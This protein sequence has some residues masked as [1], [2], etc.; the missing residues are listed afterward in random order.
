MDPN[1][2]SIMQGA[3]GA[4]GETAKYVEEVFSTDVYDGASGSNPINNG[5]DLDG[6]GGMVWFK[7]RNYDSGLSPVHDTERGVGQ[8]L[9][10]SSDAAQVAYN[11]FSSI[12]NNGFT[13][14]GTGTAYNN[15]SYKYASFTFRKAP[16]F[17]DIV[18]YTG[19]GN[20]SQTIAHSLD[21]IPG[22]IMVKCT[23]TDTTTW[24]VYHR[25]LGATKAVYL[26]LTSAEVTNVGHWNDTAPTSTH[27]TVG[28]SNDVNSLDD[29]YVAYI[30][31]HDDERFGDDEDES[32][33]KCGI[34]TG[35]G[36][37]DGPTI[38]LGWEP[39]WLIT[40]NSTYVT[41]NENWAIMDTMRQ[42]DNSHADGHYVWVS[43]NGSQPESSNAAY[44]INNQ[45]FQVAGSGAGNISGQNYI[46]MAMR[47][48]PMKTP[49]AGTEVFAVEYIPQPTSGTTK[50]TTNFPVD[51]SWANVPAQGT[52]GWTQDRVR[53][54]PKYGLHATSGNYPIVRTHDSYGESTFQPNNPY[55]LAADNTSLT[56]GNGINNGANL[57]FAFGR[58]PGFF[59]V[60]NYNA[61]G[62][63]T[64][65]IP[66][67]LGVAP[68]LMI[69]KSR[70]FSNTWWV[71]HKDLGVAA[72]LRLDDCSN[73]AESAPLWLAGQAPSSSVFTLGSG[74]FANWYGLSSDPSCI[75]YLFASL[76]GVCKI[77]SYEGTGHNG[78]TTD[79]D[80]G[81]SPRFLLI[82]GADTNNMQWALFDSA[83]GMSSSVGKFIRP[84]Q[85][86]DYASGYTGALA[87]IDNITDGVRIL[88]GN[89]GSE[90]N[91]SGDTHIYMAIA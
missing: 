72:A 63:T 90:L 5:I 13:L 67:N 91:Q 32:I 49:E 54:Y 16:G 84:N 39:Q 83:T 82:R 89:S 31:A 29:T 30:F 86:Y 79:L 85:N 18:T 88:D 64:Q 2:L 69:F 50:F 44:R 9:S 60:V 45:G 57:S 38:D 8:R 58:A 73:S 71:Y 41:Y 55:F 36:A 80:F 4:G 35:D 51:M 34:Y 47:R 25:S 10:T 28:V 48:G 24:R 42:W 7:P 68:E 75:A 3:A 77:G 56:Y 52:I 14:D 1:T 20:T 19:D 21:S 40:K 74:G 12:N 33:I 23:N 11:P 46:Y 6:E 26:D 70:G 27:F 59:D 87:I 61:N 22:M 53:G 76:P 81:F 62:G 37:A 78:G 17:F 43:A 66:H 15:S 65:S